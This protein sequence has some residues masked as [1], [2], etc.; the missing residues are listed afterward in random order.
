LPLKT[1]AYYRGIADAALSRVGSDEPPV[2][3]DAVVASLGIPVRP[4]NL[5]PFFT[6]ATVYE[7]GMP[8]MI[9]NWAKPEYERRS[10]IAHMLGHVLLVLEDPA[11]GYPRESAD[12][13][14]ADLIARE[15]MMPAKMVIEQSRLWFN[16]YRYL[17]RLFGVQESVML[18]R[19][20]E[21]GLI[22][23]PQGVMWD[24]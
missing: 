5:P 13:R 1:E 12:H 10:A 22:K 20:R 21:Q 9:V 14:E 17:A 2:P 3:I 15:L 11:H 23:G 18:D 7:D 19:M 24:Y 16:D 6:G 8:V 4:V